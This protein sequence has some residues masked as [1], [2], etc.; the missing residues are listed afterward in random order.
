MK[1]LSGDIMEKLRRVFE[2]CTNEKQ[3]VSAIAYCSLYCKM[4]KHDYPTALAMKLFI[5]SHIK[6]ARVREIIDDF[7]K[8]NE[9]A[10]IVLAS[11]SGKE[12]EGN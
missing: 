11:A 12:K 3:L 1:K 7:Q 6:R 10:G 9:Q 5:C 2:S 8:L 4:Y